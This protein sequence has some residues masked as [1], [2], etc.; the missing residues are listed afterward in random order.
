[1]FWL[2]ETQDQFETFKYT[3]GDKIYVEPIYKHPEIHP[4]IYAPLSIYI[5]NINRN[6]GYIINF[7]HPEAMSFDILQVKD[8]LKTYT[9]QIFV[10]DRKNFNYFCYTQNS[11]DILLNQKVD[12][13]KANHT[14]NYYTQ[15]YYDDIDLNAIIPI[16]KHYE[17]CEDLYTQYQQLIGKYQP[18]QYEQE[19]TDV[20]WFIERNG[21]K[22]NSAFERYFDLK[23]PFLSRYNNWVFTQ[24]NLNT[25]TGRPSNT[26]NTV[27]F[28]ALNKESGCRSV[29]IPRN[30]ILV[31]I[32]LTAYHPTLIAQ[33]VG[34]ES[35]NQDIYLDFAQQYGMDRE[36]AKNLVFKQ[37]YGHIFDQ[38]KDFEFFQLT[39]W[40]IEKTWKTF[41]AT[42]KYTV[43]ETGKVF[44]KDELPNMNPQKL[45]NYIIQHWETYN[46]VALLKEILYIMNGG[47]SKVVLYTYD[48]ILLDIRKE[49]KEK[50]TKIVDIFEQ[51]KLKVKIS[52]GTDYNALQ[53]L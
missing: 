41:E 30:D 1:M 40:L 8:Y 5:K 51:N 12:F 2:I 42:G 22:V 6:K 46:N 45:F 15:K 19:L 13:E 24:Y 47:E 49:E 18:N 17:N 16:V 32:D 25:V 4:G 53:S 36:E 50:L 26:F 7:S 33:I 48:A 3:V 20:F 35:P 28:A 44:S 37:L 27:N 34:Y 21:L 31:E 38:Y 29:F 43:V 39:S 11:Y 9:G 14:V 23:R 10:K 52:Y